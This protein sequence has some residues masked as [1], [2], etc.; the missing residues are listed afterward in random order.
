MIFEISKTQFLTPL[1]KRLFL[2]NGFLLVRSLFCPTLAKKILS[3]AKCLEQTNWKIQYGG[4]TAFIDSSKK[5][6]T[7]F[8][9]V[10][11]AQPVT[12]YIKSSREIL[13]C[14]L[15]NGA[16]H[17]LEIDDAF[18]SDSELHIRHSNYK[19]IIP[20]HQDNF[21]F[22]FS[23]PLALTCYVYLTEQSEIRGGLGFLPTQIPNKTLDHKAGMIEGFSSFH[24]QMEDI[25]NE[26]V[27][28]STKPG[29]VVFHHASTFHRAHKNQTKNHACSISV[30]IFSRSSLEKDPILQQMYRQNLNVNRS[31][32]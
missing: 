32:S 14:E 26:F 28:P 21:Y 18:Y 23:N 12:S 30:R 27:Y 6:N 29:D 20:A 9:G 8:F 24:P 10:S 7:N 1:A 15:L 22:G 11:Y 4:Q 2:S 17:L 16:N 25:S 31:A 19:H 5:D 3:E 13:G